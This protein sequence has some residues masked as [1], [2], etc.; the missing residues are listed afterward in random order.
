MANKKF[1][2]FI[3]GILLS[4]N[5]ASFSFCSA[6]YDVLTEAIANQSGSEYLQTLYR[7][8]RKE[9]ENYAKNQANIAQANKTATTLYNQ[10][11]KELDDFKVF[12]PASLSSFLALFSFFSLSIPVLR[13][14]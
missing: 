3:T 9:Q 4:C 5:I 6:N 8:G 7:A 12:R 1:K 11:I 14:C 2:R 10:S 13:N